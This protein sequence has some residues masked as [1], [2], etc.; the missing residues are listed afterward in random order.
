MQGG[1]HALGTVLQE[2]GDLGASSVVVL[3]PKDG[4]DGAGRARTV[5]SGITGG[6][7][8]SSTGLFGGGGM[9]GTGEREHRVSSVLLYYR[10]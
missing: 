8:G 9:A 2:L 6:L 1:L 4:A 5:R 7:R 10:L 3:S